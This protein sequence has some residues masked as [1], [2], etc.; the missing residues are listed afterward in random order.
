[1]R[2]GTGI[3]FKKMEK[4]NKN[5][6]IKKQSSLEKAVIWNIQSGGDTQFLQPLIN[7]KINL[8]YIYTATDDSMYTHRDKATT[9]SKPKLTGALFF[10]FGENC[11]RSMWT[12]PQKNKSKTR[13]DLADTEL[14]GLSSNK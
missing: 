5:I 12:P 1:M 10:F 11:K 7:V 4:L 3:N 2:L 9:E 8:N 13:V 6:Y 14:T